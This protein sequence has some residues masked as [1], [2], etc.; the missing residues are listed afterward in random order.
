MLNVLLSHYLEPKKKW[1][2]LVWASCKGYINIVKLLLSK[3]AAQPYTILDPANQIVV[4]G[5]NK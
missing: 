5:L 3:G 2:P 1:T 4:M